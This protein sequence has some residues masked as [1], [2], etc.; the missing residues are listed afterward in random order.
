VNI[1]TRLKN[2]FKLGKL[3]SVDDS[4]NIRLCTAKYLGKQQQIVLFTPYGL[5]HNPPVDSLVCIGDQLAQA[6]NGVG[7]ADDP[8]NR[9]FKDLKEGEVAV[10]NYMTGD[11]V[12]FDEDGNITIGNIDNFPKINLNADGSISLIQSL[13]SYIGIEASGDI[14]IKAPNVKITGALTNNTVNVGSTHVHLA[15]PSLPKLTEVPQ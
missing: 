7:V 13:A 10:G 9:I 14:E 4:G 5:M 1:L 3:L 8:T 11:Y 12:K 6:S 2:L 15:T